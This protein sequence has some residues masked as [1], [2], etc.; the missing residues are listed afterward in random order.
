[1]RKT[2]AVATAL[3]AVLAIPAAASADY[4]MSRAQAQYNTRDAARTLYGSYGVTFNG[5]IA[6]C[7]PQSTRYDARYNY[8]RWVCGWAGRDVDG[9][10]ASGSL[11][12]TGHSDGT[13]GYMVLRGIHWN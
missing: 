12:I 4:T 2:L 13:Y 10:I 9:D 7:R 8:H 6:R 1:M 11:R 3:A 5:T